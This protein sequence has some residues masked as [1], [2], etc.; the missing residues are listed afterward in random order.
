MIYKIKLEMDLSE[1]ELKN[2]PKSM[3]NQEGQHFVVGG[4]VVYGRYEQYDDAADH[5]ETLLELE[6]AV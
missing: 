2:M 6:E 5:V 3:H 4:G 1:R